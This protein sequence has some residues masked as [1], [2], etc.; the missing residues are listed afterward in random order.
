MSFE[1][2]ST[3]DFPAKLFFPWIKSCVS[4][5]N[6]APYC[7][8]LLRFSIFIIPREHE[9]GNGYL[10]FHGRYRL[11]KG[12]RMI[13]FG[14]Y[15]YV[16]IPKGCDVSAD[17]G[18]CAGVSRI[19]GTMSVLHTL[20][21]IQFFTQPLVPSVRRLNCRSISSRKAVG[22]LRRILPPNWNSQPQNVGLI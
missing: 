12:L 22:S 3:K 9:H 7:I 17:Q 20:P 19:E 15:G 2:L 11:E 10:T 6:T 14:R 1:L 13:L 5:G 16:R 4:N 18:V 8:L 21:L